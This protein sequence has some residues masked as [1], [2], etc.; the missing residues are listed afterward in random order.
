MVIIMHQHTGKVYP[1]TLHLMNIAILL[2][3][4][5]SWF[6]LLP[7]L[8]LQRYAD[9]THVFFSYPHVKRLIKEVIN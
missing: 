6:C 7:A 1:I 2:L 3:H 8:L 5:D 9:D 4:A